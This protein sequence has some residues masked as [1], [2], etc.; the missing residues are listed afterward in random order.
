MLARYPARTAR[1]ADKVPRLLGAF[2]A[3][4]RGFGREP[5]DYDLIEGFYVPTA[6]P[7][8]PRP[9][10]RI[11]RQASDARDASHWDTKAGL[12]REAF[13][14]AY[15]LPDRGWF[16]VALDLAKRPVDAVTSN[17]DHCLWTGSRTR[18]KPPWSRSI[19]CPTTCFSGW[20]IRTL[21]ASMAAYNPMSYHNGPV[22]PHDNALCAAGLM[23]YGF[24][25]YAQRVAEAVLDAAGQFGHRLPELFCGLPRA[26]YPVPV[27]YP[28]SFSPQAS[29]AAA[30]LQLLHSLLGLAPQ[31][32][33]GRAS[34]APAIPERYLPLRVSGLRL[35][36]SRLTI[37][38][39]DGGWEQPGRHGDRTHPGA[40]AS[41]RPP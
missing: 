22:W 13:N 32:S 27:P 3:A 2:G 25:G 31:L 38:V 29:A 1:R 9:A 35:G 26:D 41:A 8:R 11:A 30:P 15:W 17:T 18:T 33:A 10:A 6:P 5:L 23:R 34:C 20:G 14:E 16:A 21:A 40:T 4:G 37:D 28:T 12:L 19:C 36:K 24:A 7:P 39:H